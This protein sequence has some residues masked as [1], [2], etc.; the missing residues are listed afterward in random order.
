MRV[1]L[2]LVVYFSVCCTLAAAR[3]LPFFDIHTGMPY[4]FGLTSDTSRPYSLHALFAACAV[5]IYFAFALLLP[6]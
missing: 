2:A 3:P 4:S 6:A 5:A 1:P